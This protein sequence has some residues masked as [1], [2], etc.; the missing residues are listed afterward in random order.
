MPFPFFVTMVL[1]YFDI[2]E[3][4]CGRDRRVSKTEEELLVRLSSFLRK[5]ESRKRTGFRIK[6]GMTEIRTPCSKTTGNYQVKSL[7][8]P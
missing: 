7:F 5:Q 6:C 1:Y 4:P 3:E 2:N 8:G